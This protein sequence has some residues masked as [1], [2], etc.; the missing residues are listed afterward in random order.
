MK[1]K[2]F[3]FTLLLTAGMIGRAAAQQLPLV[4]SVEN[5]GADCPKPPLPTID[6]CPSISSLPDPFLW[7][8]GRGRI[9]SFSDWRYRRA[10]LKAM[11]EN[12]EIGVKPDRPDTITAT[13]AAGK[14]TVI[15]TKNGQSLTL[16]STIV[17]P[18]GP[19]PFP[20]VI[21]MNSGS[22]SIPADIFT[23]RNVATIAFMHNQVVTYGSK[24]ATDPYYKLYPDLFY[25][26][27]YSSWAWGVSRLIDGLELVQKDLPIDLKHIA[28]TGC[29]YAGKMAL[30]SGAFDERVALTIAQESGGGGAANWRVSQTLGPVENL[31]ST[32]H[33]WFMESMFQF[34]GANVSKLPEDHHELLAMVAPRGLF[35]LGNPDYVWL[36]DESGYVSDRAAQVIYKA[37]GVPDRFGFSI[38]GGHSH[39]ALPSSERPEVS[40]FVDKFLCGKDTTNTNIATTTYTTNLAPW[41]PWSAPTLTNTPSYFSR[42]SLVSPANQVK[43]TDNSVTCKWIKVQD[44]AKYLIQLSTNGSFATILFS[45]STSTDTVKTFAGLLSGKTYYW[46]VQ[47]KNS[48]GASGPFSDVWNFTTFVSMPGVPTLVS[49]LPYSS[50]PD[51][52]VLKWNR[53]VNVD[54]YAYQIATDTAFGN[55]FASATTADTTKLVPFL[56]IPQ[57]Y[58]WRVQATNIAGT[59]PWSV[60]GNFTLLQVPSAL[61]LQRSAPNEITLTWTENSTLQSGYVI[62]RK[63]SPQ[64]TFSVLDTVFGAGNT[65]VD[66]KVQLSQTY[67]YRVKA[68]SPTAETGYSNEMSLSLTGVKE[69]TLPTEYSIRQNYPNPFNPSTTF[70]FSLPARSFVSLK[71]FDVMGR[72]V[73]TIVADNLNAGTY[74]RQW[75]AATMTGGVYFYR[76]H[77]GTFTETRSLILLK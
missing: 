20:A 45:D 76:L 19:G 62:E 9:Q 51:N 12:Y 8:D 30:F 72:E 61:S 16:T 40:A 4:Y 1:A 46:R 77:A 37:L 33:K 60:V 67:T 64:T 74:A 59:G 21:G 14:L 65:Y 43:G 71:V 38:V 17:L 15:V 25:T 2:L 10:E 5:T 53:V 3:L 7:Q 54:T 52:V 41:I 35:V 24:L 47:V 66:K 57:K 11:I 22:G 75:N 56:S 18:A 69:E 36:A 70:T 49:A 73:A 31:G 32:D 27:Q 42:T 13:Y 48:A 34:S 44:A 23:S 55:V 68:Y 39:C 6:Q 26:G 58:Y 28:V 63:Q 29:S 50:R